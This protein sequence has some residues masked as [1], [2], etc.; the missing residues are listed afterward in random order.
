[1]R[2]RTFK[3][4][5]SGLQRRLLRLESSQRKKK[6]IPPRDS[7]TDDDYN[8]LLEQ[9]YIENRVQI[10]RC[11]VSIILP[12]HNRARSIGNAIDSIL[13]QSHGNY[14]IIVCDDGST[15]NTHEILKGRYGDIETLRALPLEKAGVSCARNSGLDAATGDYIAFLDS[16]N[17]WTPNYLRRM[18]A[19]CISENTDIAYSGLV[20]VDSTKQPIWFLGQEFD[21]DACRKNNYVDLNVY[22]YRNI[23]ALD[24]RFD[25]SLKRMV[26]WDFILRQTRGQKV[27]F[28]P[29]IGCLYMHD[30]EDKGRITVKEFNLYRRIVQAR[31]RD[32]EPLLDIELATAIKL[33]IAIKVPAPKSQAKA[34]GDFHFA[35]SLAQ[36]FNRLG[37]ETRVDLLEKWSETANDK[38]DDVV[39]VLRGLSRY[40]PR[41][42]AFNIMWNISHS[43]QVE[44]SELDEY[45]LVYTASESYSRL[46]S[47]LTETTVKPLYQA[48]DV[49]RFNP[50]RRCSHLHH[51]ILFTGNSRGVYRDIVRWTIGLGLSP[52]IYGGQWENFIPPSLIRGKNIAND[53]LGKYYASAGIVLNDHWDS[54]REY[55]L[56]SNRIFDGLACNAVVVSDAIPSLASVF[57]DAVIQ[58]S[59]PED[60]GKALLETPHDQKV[61]SE[62]VGEIVRERH[63]FDLRARCIVDDVLQRVGVPVPATPYPNPFINSSS[64]IKV[65]LLAIWNGRSFQSSM[66]LRLLMPLTA[67]A[68][69]NR[70][71]V[72]CYRP[73]QLEGMGDMDVN[74]IQRAVCKDVGTV[75]RLVDSST[76][77]GFKLITDLDDGFIHIDTDH[78]EYE[79]YQRR[80]DAIRVLMSCADESWFS[81]EHLRD[82][83]RD[84]CKRAVVIK[85]RLDPRIWR[86]Y[87]RQHRILEERTVRILYMGTAT[88]DA[89]FNMLLDQ[90]DGLHV[91]APNAFTV[92]IIGAVRNPPGRSWLSVLA[93]DADNRMYPRFARWLLRNNNFD[94]GV[95]PLVS[96][97]FN[98][99]KSDLKILDYAALGLV[100]VV[101][102]CVPYTETAT[103]NDCAIVVPSRTGW[104]DALSA[105]FKDRDRARNVA[106][107]ATRYLWSERHVAESTREISDRLSQMLE[108]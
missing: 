80:N 67:E 100:P 102:D 90:F 13:A 23:P 51:D 57:G 45:D 87:R 70:F 46:L 101:S 89:D 3:E 6:V 2:F 74:I 53:R 16:D 66:Y 71:D 27:V 26:D 40:Q 8:K 48:T 62:A 29:L 108:V 39:I 41:P 78:P 11:K 12:T 5:A 19:V 50:E 60:L 88:H 72:H 30:L 9:F 82:V 97:R 84:Q 85:N 76:S 61:K 7:I 22:F 104:T 59:S 94:V 37:H 10:D 56:L 18:I 38:R 69:N 47:N 68:S 4:I 65:G 28:A 21:R 15:D 96:N 73:D 63:T 98:D 93:P 79:L 75:E 58:V 44:Y 14:E 86:D 33:S 42:G 43:D 106:L 105:I 95:C 91:L 32:D 99:C 81:T 54:M 49:T 107:S 24:I 77:K 64:P 52:A 83:Y 55:G 1:M 34:W 17:T 35:T 31:H 103:V 36:S 25:P 20:A 92:T